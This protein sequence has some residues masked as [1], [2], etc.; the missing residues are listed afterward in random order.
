MKY[1]Y[2][3]SLTL[4]ENGL[5]TLLREARDKPHDEQWKNI[6]VSIERADGAWEINVSWRQ[7]LAAWRG[8]GKTFDAASRNTTLR[9]PGKHGGMQI[10]R[11]PPRW[12]ISR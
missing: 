4:A 8:V 6:H 10:V 3:R 12:R 2:E 11:L 1:R 7:D 9:E 5:I